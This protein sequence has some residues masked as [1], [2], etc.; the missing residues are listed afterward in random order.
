MLKRPMCAI[1]LAVVVIIYLLLCVL[2]LPSPPGEEDVHE[3]QYISLTGQ[4]TQKEYKNHQFVLHLEKVHLQNSSELSRKTYS[5]IAYFSED[6]QLLLGSRASVTG[7]CLLFACAENEGQFDQARY[8][9]I[10]GVDFAL[11]GT[12]V[13]AKGIRYHRWEETLYQCREH[14]K[15]VYDRCL[16]QKEAG[17]LHALLLGDKTSLDQE[18]KELYTRAGIVHILSLSG[19]KTELLALLKH[20]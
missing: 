8:Q 15:A 13:T 14:L 9:K 4:V 2:R 11:T 7:K 16:P 3:G 20:P 18:V 10:N 1:G 6:P 17:I 12:R 5:I 19:V